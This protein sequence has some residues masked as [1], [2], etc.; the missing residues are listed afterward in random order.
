M[1]IKGNP[2]SAGPGVSIMTDPIKKIKDVKLITKMLADQPRNQCLFLL[3]INNGLRITDLLALKVGQVRYLKPGESVRIRETKT[4][5]W[6]HLFVNKTTHKALR[7]YL[8]SVNLSDDDYLFKSKKGN[9]PLRMESVNQL[10]KS[11]CKAA[12]IKGNF[13]CR[14]L[15]KTFGYHQRA[16]FGVGYDVLARRFN[17]DSPRTTMR[18]LGIADEEVEKIALNEIG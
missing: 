5:K 3:G 14:T 8:G 16:T 17:H 12:K 7:N 13:G 10:I 1:P 2:N 4:G 6:N 11:W 18:Y 15:R 9:Q